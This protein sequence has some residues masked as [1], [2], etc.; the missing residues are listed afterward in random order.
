[1][2]RQCGDCKEEVQ[3]DARFCPHCG[4]RFKGTIG[5]DAESIGRLFDGCYG[6]FKLCILALILTV[7]FAI[8]VRE[9]RALLAAL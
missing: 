7:I 9:I 5:R 6:F 3:P 1:M 8:V 4:V 2:T